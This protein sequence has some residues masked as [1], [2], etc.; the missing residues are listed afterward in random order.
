MKRRTDQIAKNP[1]AVALGRLGR[2]IKKHITAERRAELRE[3]AKYA[4]ER[5]AARAAKKAC[6]T[7]TEE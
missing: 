2:T 4:R 5:K 7:L 6:L 1:A 3:A